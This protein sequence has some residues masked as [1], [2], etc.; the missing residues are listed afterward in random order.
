MAIAVANA[1]LLC[2]GYVRLGWRKRALAVGLVTLTL[3]IL[4]GT[5]FRTVWFEI[6]FVVWWFAQV[7]HGWFLAGG[8]PRRRP[9]ARVRAGLRPALALALPLLL[10]VSLLRLDVARIN[11]DVAA[12]VRDGDCARATKALD[13]RTWAHYLVDGPGAVRSDSTG[14]VCSRIEIADG[15]FDAVLRGDEAALTLGFD[16]LADVLADAPGHEHMVDAVLDRFL[17]RLPLRDSCYT[18]TILDRLR[19]RKPTG[20]LLDRA[21]GT[22]PRLAPAAIVD[23]GDSLLASQKWEPARTTYQRLLDEYP[24]DKLAGRATDGARKAGQ[25]IELAHVRE[26]LKT[27]A[28]G[29]PSGYCAGPAPYS[30]AAPYGG[31]GPYRTLFIGG[32]KYLNG[33]PAEWSTHDIAD[34]VLAVCAGGKGYGD[35]TR[36]CSYESRPGSDGPFTVTFHKI[37]ISVKVYEV[38]TARLV[39]DIRLQVDGV[40]CPSN[41]FWGSFSYEE[42][43]APGD[44]FVRVS[45][46]EIAATVRDALKP[47]ID[48]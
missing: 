31:D 39:S 8:W 19:A 30:G 41:I 27:G 33:L 48:P 14:P 23:C 42:S 4:L 2:V 13:R 9:R 46:D 22:V 17:D 10:F 18:V 24:G 45:D 26:L 35:A 3:V 43:R 15:Q 16:G 28:Q 47:V 32:S 6:V 1:S 40:S 34:A 38:R 21:G 11:G 12:A 5:A 37:A 7:A 44:M 36:S 20:D 25:Q 29:T